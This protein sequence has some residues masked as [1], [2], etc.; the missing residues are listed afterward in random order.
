MQSLRLL[1][2]RD[3]KVCNGI[4]KSRRA[5]LTSSGS[6]ADGRKGETP[7]DRAQR[8]PGAPLLTAPFFSP[9]LALLSSFDHGAPRALLFEGVAKR[10][11]RTTKPHL[12]GR[13]V[14][15]RV[16]GDSRCE[17]TLPQTSRRRGARHGAPQSA[18]SRVSDAPPVTGTGVS[19][20]YDEHVKTCRYFDARKTSGIYGIYRGADGHECD[21][22]RAHL[23]REANRHGTLAVLS[24]I[25]CSLRTQLN[26][27]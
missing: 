4:T 20:G 1:V 27:R 5:K 2:L 17:N 8:Q 25:P 3:L 23:R 18:G 13:G 10:V 15:L 16:P 24:R 6:G 7:S 19:S 21:H 14:L 26:A 22:Q 11:E 12:P 9:P